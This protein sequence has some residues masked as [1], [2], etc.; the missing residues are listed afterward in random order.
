MGSHGRIDALNHADMRTSH[1]DNCRAGGAAQSTGTKAV[2]PVCGM[3]VDP[4]TTAH[5]ASH[6]GRDNYFEVIALDAR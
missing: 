1:G 5:R 4:A 3:T 2:D 6:D